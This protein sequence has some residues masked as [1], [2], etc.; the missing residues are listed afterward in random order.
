MSGPDE[1]GAAPTVRGPV[2]LSWAALTPSERLI[3]VGGVLTI[4]GG[5]LN[6][7]VQHVINAGSAP[8]VIVAAGFAVGSVFTA[9]RPYAANWP[10]PAPAVMRAGANIVALFAILDLLELVA[11]L[12]AL[13]L[14][15]DVLSLV[16]PILVLAG[17][18]ALSV[19]ALRLG[20]GRAM[21]DVSSLS[22]PQYLVVGG[23]SLALLGWALML[24]VGDIFEVGFV[25]AIGIAAV[26]LAMISVPMSREPSVVEQ[27][28]P[29]DVIV[30]ALA[31]GAIVIALVHLSEFMRVLDEFDV[32]G[33]DVVGPY[34]VWIIGVLLVALGAMLWVRDDRL[35]PGTD[36][37]Q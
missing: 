19:G 22:R 9:G 6:I 15:D 20:S 32:G 31:A 36:R 29:W 21:P 25:P 27:R 12:S 28:I 7:V 33:L 17:A 14:P 11:D 37:A 26:A 35:A 23:G 3:V 34:A 16:A 18:A 13:D 5:L 4:T 8:I 24:T 1:I 10:L 2:P 30:A